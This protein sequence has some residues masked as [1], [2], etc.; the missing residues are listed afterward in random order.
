MVSFGFDAET[1]PDPTDD[2][3]PSAFSESSVL[4]LL[5][6]LWDPANETFDRVALGLGPIYDALVGGQRTTD[7]LTTLASFITALKAEAGVDAAAVDD[8]LA[9]YQIGPIVSE[10][11]EGDDALSAMYAYASPLPFSG[12]IGLGGGFP[13][14]SWQQNQ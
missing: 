9:A 14:N 10:W 8:L 11:G 6:D 13:F 2:P 1:E 5:Y 7:A 12:T 4:R 3:T